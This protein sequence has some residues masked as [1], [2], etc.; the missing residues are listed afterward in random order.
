MNK[1]TFLKLSA[2]VVL[3]TILALGSVSGSAA[4]SAQQA[5]APATM[6]GMSMPGGMMMLPGLCPP[7]L[8]K[9][10]FE[11]SK[12][13]MTAGGIMATMPAI[14]GMPGGM[15]PTMPA[16]PG[17][18]GMPGM[19]MTMPAMPGLPGGMVMTMP[20]IPI[21]NQT[22]QITMLSGKNEIPGPGDA[23]GYGVAG[24]S[25]DGNT[26]S[27]TFEVMVADIKLPATASHIH[28]S[29]AG[30]SGSVVVDAKGAPDAQGM[31][32]NTV[33]GVDAAL[34]DDIVKNPTGYYYNV[35]NADFPAGA[36]RGQLGMDMMTMV[37]GMMPPMSGTMPAAPPPAK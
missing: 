19:V 3:V 22:C 18:P 15:M 20:A 30:T 28:K 2:V 1:Q 8:V 12:A 21:M 10:L 29:A 27:I 13:M 33:T 26:K 23:K 36:I 34:F 5:T 4:R 31:F 37:N 32:K 6:A 17:M 35:H 14:P 24:I 7:G 25:F 9:G 16:M 11:A